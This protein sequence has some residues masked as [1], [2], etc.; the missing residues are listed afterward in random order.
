MVA[1]GRHREAAEVVLAGLQSP[2]A[3]LATSFQALADAW[4]NVEKGLEGYPPTIVPQLC[5]QIFRTLEQLGVENETDL[6]DKI[7]EELSGA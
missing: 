3:T 2:N 6:W 5:I 1:F 7:A 4:D